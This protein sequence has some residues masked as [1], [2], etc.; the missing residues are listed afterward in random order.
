[1]GNYYDLWPNK[2]KA[3]IHEIAEV[4]L[5]PVGRGEI[6]K[7]QAYVVPD[8]SQVRNEH[9]EIVKTDYPH[10]RDIWFSDVS[11][12]EEILSIDALIG[13][14]YLWYFQEGETIR[15]EEAHDPVAVKTKLGWVLSGP[16]KGKT[17]VGTVSINL[18]VS[19]SVTYPVGGSNLEGE[20]K[21]LWDLETLGIREEESMHEPLFDNISFNGT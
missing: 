5:S 9:V 8:I 6:V 17:A 14:D 1:M 18:N 3:T 4:N 2:G 13:S 20:V 7:I 15:G 16:L 10:L 21:K 19:K 11:K 12:E